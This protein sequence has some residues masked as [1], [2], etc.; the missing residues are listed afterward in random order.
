MEKIYVFLWIWF[1]CLA[2][3]TT[4]NTVQWIAVVCL[5]WQ[6]IRFVRQYL[7]ALKLTTNADD[8]ECAKFVKDILGL[9]G[10]FLLQAVSNVSSDLIALD[11]TASMWWNYRQARL[12]G[13][14]DDISR[15]LDH[16][17]STSNIV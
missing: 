14:E 5:P 8:R 4:V 9:D 12:V 6:Q 16:A 1:F 17:R 2:I 10:I 3:L 7:K 11:V 13:I 15:F